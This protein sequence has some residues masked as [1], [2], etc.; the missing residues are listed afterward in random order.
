MKN[1][2]INRRAR[3]VITTIGITSALVF[4]CKATTAFAANPHSISIKHI[5]SYASGMFDQ[6]AAEIV[7]YDPPSRNVFA[8][9]A[10][11]S[12]LDV[13][14]IADPTHPTKV[15]T[16]DLT[17]YGAVV[18]SV[19]VHDGVIAVA[20]QDPVKTNP[21]KAVFFD[22]TFNFLSQVTVGA[23]P[24]MISSGRSD[25]A[26]VLSSRIPLVSRTRP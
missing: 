13:I 24:D 11:A 1:N 25:A 6:G 17:P 23:Q 18:D 12:Q 16:I 7:A 4:G 9:N 2:T 8:I 10:E 14:S 5:G 26:A 21:G 15:T 3:R 22:R 19:A 20:I